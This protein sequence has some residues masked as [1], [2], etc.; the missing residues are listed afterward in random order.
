MKR[1]SDFALWAAL[2][3]TGSWSATILVGLIILILFAFGMTLLG[4]S[5]PAADTLGARAAEAV[6]LI[7]LLATFVGVPV[8]AWRH[9]VGFWRGLVG[10]IIAASWLALSVGAQITFVLLDK[11]TAFLA[12]AVVN[13]LV[14][15]TCATILY[16]GRQRK[17]LDPQRIG[18]V[19]E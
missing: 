19:F 13:C 8:L 16:R 11:K 17:H 2:V 1:V 14:S 4:V 18:Q 7:A 10:V 12:G 3:V 6:M 15:V 5:L 9:H